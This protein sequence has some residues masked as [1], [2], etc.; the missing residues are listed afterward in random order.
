MVAR[1]AA[2]P[3]TECCLRVSAS[4]SGATAATTPTLKPTQG[5]SERAVAVKTGVQGLSQGSERRVRPS[6]TGSSWG[7]PQRSGR[8]RST[9]VGGGS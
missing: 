2:L 6:I 9:W 7:V 3:N 8:C 5:R 4:S 1:W